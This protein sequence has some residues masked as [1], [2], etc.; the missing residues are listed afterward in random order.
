MIE[1][2]I[3]LNCPRCGTTAEHSGTPEECARFKDGERRIF[4]CSCG[5]D[6]AE[7]DWRRT[8]KMYVTKTPLRD[9]LERDV[10]RPV[11][12]GRISDPNREEK[13]NFRF[14]LNRNNLYK[15][16][17][18]YGF[19]FMFA[20]RRCVICGESTTCFKFEKNPACFFCRHHRDRREACGQI[21]MFGI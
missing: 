19:T 6:L 12:R 9:I 18:V 2:K 16:A 8:V 4:V 13:R 1:A 14:I 10:L 20:R 7:F 11:L 5:A 21:S 3:T 15:R 17:L